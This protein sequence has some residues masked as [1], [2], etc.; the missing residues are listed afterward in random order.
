MLPVMHRAWARVLFT[1]ASFVPMLGVFALAGWLVTSLGRL[2][3]A[4]PRV[5]M[6]QLIVLFGGATL[7]AFWQ[8]GLGIVVAIQNA[9]ADKVGS[10]I[11]VIMGSIFVVCVLAFRR[12]IVGELNALCQ[13]IV[14]NRR[15]RPAPRHAAV[16]APSHDETPA[17][18]GVHARRAEGKA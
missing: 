15:G 11:T 12:G 18:A 5:E 16:P 2:G 4:V 8:M 9:L 1:I 13:N 6:E 14:G 3:A 10:M 17:G 7:I